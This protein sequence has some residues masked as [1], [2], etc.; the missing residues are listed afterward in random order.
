MSLTEDLKVKP[1]GQI[2]FLSESVFSCDP[3]R[4]QS[5]SLLCKNHICTLRTSRSVAASE[6]RS[7]PRRNLIADL[8]SGDFIYTPHVIAR[9]QVSVCL[10]LKT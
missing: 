6:I 2:S 3:V 8:G 7:C 5:Q 1:K 4:L 9:I 10:K